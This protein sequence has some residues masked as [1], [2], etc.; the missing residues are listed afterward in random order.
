MPQHHNRTT[1]Q[2]HNISKPQYRNISIPQHL[3]TTPQYHISPPQHLN[4]TPHYHISISQC[5]TSTPQHKP[6]ILF[7]DWDPSNAFP[8]IEQIKLNV[9]FQTS[10]IL[11]TCTQAV[12]LFSNNFPHPYKNTMSLYFFSSPSCSPLLSL[13]LAFP[14]G[15]HHHVIIECI[16]CRLH[17][18]GNYC[19]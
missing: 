17:R 9:G 18:Q 3:N 2:H 13:F 12:R 14:P 10:V 11:N 1:S 19:Y 6:W 8:G 4:T 15:R 7:I 16:P 5:F